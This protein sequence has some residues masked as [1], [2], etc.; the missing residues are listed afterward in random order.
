MNKIKGF[1]TCNERAYE[2]EW[3]AQEL[4]CQLQTL[5]QLLDTA[6]NLHQTIIPLLPD[7]ERERQYDWFSSIE[8]YSSTF[9]NDVIQWLD[10]KEHVPNPVENDLVAVTKDVCHFQMDDASQ[11]AAQDTGS[12]TLHE[13]PQDDEKP[14]DSISN[15]QSRWSAQSAASGKSSGS[16]KRSSVSSTSSARI[17]A[18][19]DL[20]A[21][22]ARQ[23]LLQDK[24]ALEEEEQQIRKRKERLKLDEEIAAHLAKMNVLRAASTSGSKNTVTDW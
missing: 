13:G 24:H 2:M 8:K 22:M 19:A 23:K 7:D 10:G 6:V 12:I 20:A 11:A 21:L 4:K 9:K 1:N 5:T 3:N 14:S 18:E 15:V 16:G 17:K